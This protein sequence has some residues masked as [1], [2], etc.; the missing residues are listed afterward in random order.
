V[1]NAV[2]LAAGASRRFG[3]ANKLTVEFDGRPLIRDP[4]SAIAVRATSLAM[5][6]KSFGAQDEAEKDLTEGRPK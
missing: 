4:E 3:D 2:L 1:G 5:P 6:S